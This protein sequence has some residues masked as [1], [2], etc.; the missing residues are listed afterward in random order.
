RVAVAFFH[1]PKNLVVSAILL[2]YIDHVF[3][4]AGL[5]GFARDRVA[6]GSIDRNALVFSEW[7]TGVGLLAVCGHF[8]GRRQVD[9]A[10][11]APEQVGDILA[12]R[13]VA[14]QERVRPLW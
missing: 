11:R 2:D 4:W 1:I 12:R 10:E 14:W 13:K 9:D 3:D 6:H 8:L 5:P 7:T